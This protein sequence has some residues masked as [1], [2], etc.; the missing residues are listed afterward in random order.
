[1]NGDGYDDIIVGA[2]FYALDPGQGA[3]F[4][5]FGSTSGPGHRARRPI[6]PS[7]GGE[8][9]WSV[10]T[11]G[12]VNGDG[13]ADVIVGAPTYTDFSQCCGE[14]GVAIVRNGEG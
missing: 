8:L 4:T 5:Y 2:P 13:Y 11:A 1:V 7:S 12:D 9:G 3:A 6:A 14:E 10:A